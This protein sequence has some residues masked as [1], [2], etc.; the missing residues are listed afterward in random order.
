MISTVTIRFNQ[1]DKHYLGKNPEIMS[2][3]GSESAISLSRYPIDRTCILAQQDIPDSWRR[4]LLRNSWP[5][6]AFSMCRA[7]ARNF[8]RDTVDRLSLTLSTASRLWRFRTQGIIPWWSLPRQISAEISL[9]GND[10][11]KSN[12]NSCRSASLKKHKITF[13]R[14]FRAKIHVA[15]MFLRLLFFRSTKVCWYSHVTRCISSTFS[16]VFFSQIQNTKTRTDEEDLFLETD[17]DFTRTVL[18]RAYLPD[19]SEAK[20]QRYKKKDKGDI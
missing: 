17:R 12:A 3:H 15:I 10:L 8:N 5:E 2:H 9:R 18:Y 20:T 19:S 11:V 1:G 7:L 14:E 6:A 13:F 4:S 16:I